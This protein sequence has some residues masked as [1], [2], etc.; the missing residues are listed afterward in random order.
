MIDTRYSEEG[1]LRMRLADERGRNALSES[2]IRSIRD[3]L[4]RAASHPRGRMLL[5]EGLPEIFCSGAAA[6]LLETVGEGRMDSP[7]IGL[8]EELLSFPLPVI[9]SLEGAALGGGLTLALCAD[10][11]VAS[12]SRR[13]GFNFTDLG[14]TPGMGTTAIL[15]ALVG[16]HRAAEMMLTGA[17]YKGRELADS[18]LFNYV[19]PAN[20]VEQRCLELAERLLDKPLHVLRLLKEEISRPRLARLKEALPEEKRM[21]KIC[22]GHPETEERIRMN[23]IGNS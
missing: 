23:V 1:L 19:L 7:E 9:A 2:M 6:S 4:E 22:F 12:E 13:Y 17:S 11:T 10:I 16:Y 15:P 8:A 3:E 18:G 20:R 5:L 14:F 21:H